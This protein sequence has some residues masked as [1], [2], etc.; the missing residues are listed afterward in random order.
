MPNPALCTE[1]L[2]V[3]I[4]TGTFRLFL[5]EENGVEFEVGDI[6]EGDFTFTPQ[7]IEHRRGLD[8][9]LDGI[10]SIGKDYIINFTTHSLTTKNIAVLLNEPTVNTV[11]GCKV[12]FTGGTCVLTYGARM[13]IPFQCNDKLIEITMWRAQIL[14]EFT[15]SFTREDFASVTG[16]IKALDCSSVHPNEPFGQWV[17]LNAACAS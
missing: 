11:D 14:S 8:N 15:M 17:E 6:Q 4:K 2:E 16:S 13:L 1:S 3:N 7:T 5:Q 9:S 12:P 10:F